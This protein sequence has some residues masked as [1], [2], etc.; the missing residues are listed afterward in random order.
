MENKN[1][2]ELSLEELDRVIGGASL[3]ER[4][5]QAIEKRREIQAAADLL[6]S[7]GK[8]DQTTTGPSLDAACEAWGEKGYK[9]TNATEFLKAYFCIQ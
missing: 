5:S 8:L 2:R 6:I 9:P 3:N 1:S 4:D 7:Q